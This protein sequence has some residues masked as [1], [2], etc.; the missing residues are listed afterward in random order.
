MVFHSIDDFCAS[1]G[2]KNPVLTIGNFDGVHLGHR[3]LVEKTIT[4]AR[5]KNAPAVA[6]TFNPHPLAVLKMGK[7]PEFLL[8]Y[9]EKNE[10]LLS[11]GLD[12]VIEQPFVREFSNLS[13][14]QF[15]THYLIKQL[16]VQALVI[17]YDFG[18]GKEREGSQLILQKLCSQN[19]IQLEIVPA[20][21]KLGAA[22]SSTRI[23]Q[24]LSSGDFDSA[25]ELLGYSFYYQGAVIKGDQRGRTIGFPTANLALRDKIKIP[26]GVYATRTLVKGE[27]YPSVTNI[28]VRPTFFA[29]DSGVEAIIETHLLG[30]EI[31]LYG[32]NIKVEFLGKIREEKKFSGIDELKKQIALDAESARKINLASH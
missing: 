20:F 32:V 26:F 7:A 22:I 13:A 15:F 18:F 8:T 14:E 21:K 11:L 30:Q 31:D 3:E 1:S 23:R 6:L 9:R 2:K 24:S 28:G 17:G 4:I 12:S 27:T 19:G 5:A 10:R 16:G 25:K 29:A